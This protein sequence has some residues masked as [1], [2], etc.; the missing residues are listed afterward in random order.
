M[1][2]VLVCSPFAKRVRWIVSTLVVACL[3]GVDGQEATPGR[4]DLGLSGPHS[5]YVRFS[6]GR[7]K[8]DAD[9]RGQ[10]N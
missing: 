3:P 1:A 10:A 6:C 5:V 4:P 8:N 2:A 9:R 7:Q